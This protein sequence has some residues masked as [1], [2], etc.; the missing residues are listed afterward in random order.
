MSEIGGGVIGFRE[1]PCRRQPLTSDVWPLAFGIWH[2]TS[3][4]EWLVDILETL[5]SL[6]ARWG[7]WIVFFG[8]MIENA[9]IPVPGET[10]LL[11]A[12]FFA[13]RGFFSLPVVMGIAATGAIIGDNCGYWIGRRLG[14]RLLIRYGKYVFL[15]ENRF[16]SMERFFKG[17][18]DKMVISA[19][20][21]T[22]FRVFTALF[23]GASHMVWPRFLLFNALGAILW[24]V[25]MGLLGFF[26]GHSW[27]LLERWIKGSGLILAGA[28]LLA[29]AIITVVKRRKRAIR[30]DAD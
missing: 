2:L 17:H 15:T 3:D 25:A 28:V 23:A 8:V 12:G 9:G 24:S 18:G 26:F 22:G 7:Y 27:A 6:M 19:R 14:R 1:P 5:T 4:K 21:I 11:A 29:L 30:P 16:Q 13:S 10:I 20:F